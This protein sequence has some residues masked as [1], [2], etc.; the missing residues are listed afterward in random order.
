[1]K[2]TFAEVTMLAANTSL[3]Q[4]PASGFKQSD[5]MVI[6]LYLFRE[7]IAH[8][9]ISQGLESLVACFHPRHAMFY[10]A[11][12][13]KELGG[14]KSY[15]SVKGNPALAFKLNFIDLEREAGA[16]KTFFGV[17]SLVQT[18]RLGTP[19]YRFRFEEFF[20]IFGNLDPAA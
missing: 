19:F 14:L 6:L 3:L 11:L 7:T 15:G 4:D 5:Q 9:R 20:Q 8:A 10:R 17:D 13:F 12:H 18:M 1:M 2:N 16:L